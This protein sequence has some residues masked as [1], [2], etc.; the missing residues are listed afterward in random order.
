M[1]SPHP[2]RV[3]VL[4]FAIFLPWGVDAADPASEV[5][6]KITGAEITKTKNE[7]TGLSFKDCKS[8]T[9]ADYRQVRQLEGLKS[10]S[11]GF[12]LDDASLKTLEGM[13]A[14]ESFT[15]NG[16]T[17]SDEGIRTL[18]SFKALRNIC[19]FHPGKNF[20]GSGLKALAQLPNLESFSVGGSMEFSDPGMAAVATLVHLKGFRTWHTGVTVEGVKALSALK[21]LKTLAIG[22][23]LSMKPPVTLNDETVAV[24][25]EFSSLE[26]LTLQEA[27]LSLPALTKLKQLPNLKRLTL[28]GIDIPESDIAALKQELPKA[29]IK[30]TAPNEAGQRRIE[31]LFGP[32]KPQ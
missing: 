8:L 19:F 31:A 16:M 28:D 9:E 14:I 10:L 1:I 24:I 7:L 12:G 2:V 11:F 17:V 21:E 32:T 25:A 20:Q 15:T 23:R 30:W 4:A 5:V 27:R 6:A 26:A 22:Q 13:P 3:V 29:E 18:A